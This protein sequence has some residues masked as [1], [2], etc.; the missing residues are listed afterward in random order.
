MVLR[1]RCMVRLHSACT[2]KPVLPVPHDTACTHIGRSSC[3]G[4]WLGLVLNWAR[5][6]LPH[7]KHAACQLHGCQS[8]STGQ[9]AFA[10][11]LA[12]RPS[13]ATFRWFWWLRS[14]HRAPYRSRYCTLG[15]Q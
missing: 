2:S 6:S 10:R 5:Y 14:Q 3:T 1:L 11:R 4:V 9:N 15:C 7:W 8:C 13:A 12:S